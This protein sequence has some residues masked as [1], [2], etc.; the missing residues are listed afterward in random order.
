[1]KGRRSKVNLFRPIIAAAVLCA[2][3]GPSRTLSQEPDDKDLTTL[4]IEELT[5][6]RLF[7]A[8]RHLEDARKAP[9]AVTT[10]SAE[11]IQRYGWRTL[12]ELLR[13]VPGFY[14][15]YDRDYSYVGVRGF[16]QSGDYNARVLLLID[17]HRMNENVYD[18]GLI[19]TE[20]PLDMSLIDH[21]EI[22]RGPGSSLFGTD[23][24]LA[25]VNVFTRRPARH[26]TVEVATDTGSFQ[27]RTGQI[28]LSLRARGVDT[29]VSG[30]LF[31]SNGASHLYFPEF[32]SPDTNNGIADNLDGD[33]SDHAFGA[34]RKGSFRV[35]GLYS[36]RLKIVPNATYGT[37][38]NDPA[39]RSVD[40][41]AFADVGYTTT[42][43]EGSELDLR[44]YYDHYRYRGGFAYGGTNSP[45]RTVQINDAVADWIGFESV[46]GHRLGK[47]RVVAGATGEYNLRID[48]RNYNLGEPTTFSDHRN[49]GLAAVFGEAELNPAQKISLNLG[50]RVDWY[51]TFGATAS[52]RIA[53]MYLP[54]SSTSLKYIYGHAFR[55]PDAYDQYY[56][57][58]TDLTGTNP[59]LKPED[60]NS[61]NLIF[62]H[63]L[64]PWLGLS[65]DVFENHLKKIIEEQYDPTTGLS[66][67]ANLK[68]DRGRGVEVELDTKTSSGWTGRGS[69]V[70]VRALQTMTGSQVINSPSNV[71]KLNGTA[72]LMRFGTL[73]AEFL[74]EGVQ[75]NYLYQ[76]IPSSFLSNVTLTTRT[77]W[78][79]L[80]FSTSCYN[81]LDRRWATP[82][83]PEV[84]APATVQ[85]GRTWR[86]R[87][88]YRRSVT[89]RREG[90]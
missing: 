9:S 46:L 18:S 59:G 80:D 87:I 23:A 69:Y 29:I 50:G 10:I 52:P 76:R 24:E 31:R 54:T 63:R 22:V 83:G 1:V 13:S 72:P 20:F 42:L 32:D 66:T 55:A 84:A 28:T 61:Q 89:S 34:L 16:L 2:V 37:N 43:S 51:S 64:A 78:R 74:Y 11:D 48:Q 14:T 68:G 81:L 6:V 67:F 26:A 75:K 49:P 79:D 8:S 47:H 82:T 21:V 35:E 73:G 33:R 62:K 5:Q 86:F 56:V 27:S 30:S 71:A 15:A 77:P 40:T 44:A 90:K 53:L 58:G 88:E 85:D 7:T 4:S 36:S 19:G 60:I 25:V 3:C 38:F 65:A 45:D 70:F 39:N 17:G 57:D 12:A 41:R